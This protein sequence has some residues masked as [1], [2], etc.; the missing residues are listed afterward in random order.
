MEIV[1]RR[2]AERD[3]EAVN[4]LSTQLGYAM[5][6]EE[7]LANIRSVL[8][9]KGHNAFVAAYENRLIGWIGVAIALQIESAPFCEIRGLIVDETYRGHGI[10]RLLIERVKQWGKE[11]GITILRLR[12][13]T[14][15]K[16]AHLFYHHVGFKEIKEQKVFQMKI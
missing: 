3:A 1:I 9:T 10:G 11:T 5:P 15:R 6:I 12:C 14:I 2:I 7:T 13:N 4:A 16:E 8:A